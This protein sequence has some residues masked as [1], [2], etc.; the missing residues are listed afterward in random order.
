MQRSIF[1]PAEVPLSRFAPLRAVRRGAFAIG[2]TWRADRSVSGNPLTSGGRHHAWG[3]DALYDVVL[4]K[5]GYDAGL[6]A[7]VT[8]RRKA[9]TS[10]GPITLELR[11]WP[12]T[13]AA[14][15]VDP[16]VAP[17]Q[18][19]RLKVKVGSRKARV[20][21]GRVKVLE[22]RKVLAN[23][24]LKRSDK[25]SVKVD[26]GRLPKGTHHLKVLFSGK[27][28]LKPSRAKKVKVVVARS[29]RHAR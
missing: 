17:K 27:E 10:L 12:T 22:G 20:D 26:L 28:G 1:D 9:P 24:R 7:G 23:Q 21:G 29:A 8:A 15:V 4:V 11:D 16:V 3:F 19:V 6:L 2:R 5:R 18:R 14:S 25:G 13:T